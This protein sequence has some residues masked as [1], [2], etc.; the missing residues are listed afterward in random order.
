MNWSD[1]KRELRKLAATPPDDPTADD[2]TDRIHDVL[3]QCEKVESEGARPYRILPEGPAVILRDGRT[4]A[5][6]IP[7]LLLL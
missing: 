7:S 4:V 3:R 1:V 6:R 2:P 5:S